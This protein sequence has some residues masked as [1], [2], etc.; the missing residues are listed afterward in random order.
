MK[1]LKDK[2]P[3]S[4]DKVFEKISGKSGISSVVKI[5]SLGNKRKRERRQ[6]ALERRQLRESRSVNQQLELL[7][8]RPGESRKE[9]ER[10]SKKR[11]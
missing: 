5:K 7:K 11:K 8:E 3:D 4:L 1:E 6:Q 2:K 10:L 9:M